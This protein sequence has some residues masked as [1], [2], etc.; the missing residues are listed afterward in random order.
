MAAL[1]A[2]AVQVMV[3]QRGEVEAL[4]LRTEHAVALRRG[5]RQDGVR[6]QQHLRG[7]CGA[8]G[9][10]DGIM[11]TARLRSSVH[12]SAWARWGV[13]GEGFQKVILTQA[14]LKRE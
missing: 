2:P 11:G 14:D 4:Q 10:T 13:E 1:S 6:G 3:A 12:S 7:A 5:R 8:D 9:R